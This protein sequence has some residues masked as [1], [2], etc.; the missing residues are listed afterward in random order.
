MENCIFCKI[1]TGKIPSN[2]VFESKEIIAFKDIHPQA[3]IHY[4]FIPKEHFESLAAVPNEKIDVV[5]KL[6][7][8]IKNFTDKEGISAKGY[9]TTIN[10]RREGGQTVDHLHVH[11]FAGRQ[12][13][14]NMV[15]V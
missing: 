3:P 8:A 10:T 13:G 2:K 11:L 15:G 4:L 6:F 9:R 5:A 7:E 1:V 12:L 14:G